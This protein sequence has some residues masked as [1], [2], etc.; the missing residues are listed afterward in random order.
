MIPAGTKLSVV[1]PLN[2]ECSNVR[3]LFEETAAVLR[4]LGRTRAR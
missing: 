1:I 4:E 3:P 2:D